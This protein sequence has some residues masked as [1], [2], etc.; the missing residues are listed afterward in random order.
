MKNR[1]LNLLLQKLTAKTHAE[2]LLKRNDLSLTPEQKQTLK[3]WTYQL[4]HKHK[5]LQYILGDVP[6]CN[7]TIQVKKP[8]LI[9]RPE[10]EEWCTWLIEKLQPIKN[11]QL[12]ILDLCTGSGC[13]ALALAKALPESTVIG[14]DI[15]PEA[16]SLA[17][18]NKK[19]NKI[20]N[21]NFVQ[22]NLYEKLTRQTFDI[23]VSNPPYISENEYKELE[24]TVREWEDKKALVAD[25]EGFA[26]HKK[27][28]EHAKDFLRNNKLLEKYNIPQIV[29]EFGKGQEEQMKHLLKAAGFTNIMVHKDLSDIY[30][31]IEGELKQ[32]PY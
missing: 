9:P 32:I 29:M 21:V 13:I 10:T 4:D 26:I 6:F 19:L 16:I 12:R 18:T 5:P 27:I 3:Q 28:I 14:I 24:P 23:I 22:S 7:L 15:N 8:I 25:A 2:L 31:W 20:I 1:E 17:N 30:R 11:E